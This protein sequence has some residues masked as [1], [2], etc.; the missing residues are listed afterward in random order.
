MKLYKS[1]T[2]DGRSPAFYKVWIDMDIYRSR[3]F[4]P[5]GLLPERVAYWW[6]LQ[7]AGFGRWAP[8]KF[9]Q[10]NKKNFMDYEKMG[11][12]E[13]ANVI[14]LAPGHIL[15]EGPHCF[16]RFQLSKGNLIVFGSFGAAVYYWEGREMGLEELP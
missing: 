16:V 15:L 10:M 6:I 5:V 4:R 14:E 2:G 13:E 11:W 8:L 3:R 12:F 9:S 1:Y 7:P